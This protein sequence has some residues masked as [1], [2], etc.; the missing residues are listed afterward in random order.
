MVPTAQRIPWESGQEPRRHKGDDAPMSAWDTKERPAEGC[1]S[2]FKNP[3]SGA[4]HLESPSLWSS[5]PWP[6]NLCL[7]CSLCH[8]WSQL[9]AAAGAGFPVASTCTAG[10]RVLAGPGQA[11]SQLGPQQPILTWSHLNGNPVL[12]SANDWSWRREWCLW[13][14]YLILNQLYILI[15]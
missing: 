14:F 6:L 7:P 8:P 4:L 13:E 9:I 10:W 2:H 15:H 1:V 3:V 11:A 5:C 12:Q